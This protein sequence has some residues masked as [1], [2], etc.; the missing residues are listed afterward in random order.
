M[1]VTTQLEDTHR[2]PTL[3]FSA[4]SFL[5][6]TASRHRPYDQRCTSPAHCVL[7]H[8]VPLDLHTHYT[9]VGFEIK[10]VI[11]NIIQIFWYTCS[12]LCNGPL[13]DFLYW[14]KG[15]PLQFQ[16]LVSTAQK[17]TASPLQTLV[18]NVEASN[19]F[20]L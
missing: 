14:K 9:N 3:L 2:L 19:A 15:L 10:V 13:S 4:I 11:P 20:L 6:A 18:D 1:V 7:N 8:I 17:H 12:L 16:I 5:Y